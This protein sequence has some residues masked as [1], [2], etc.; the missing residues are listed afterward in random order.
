MS[1]WEG[2]S[3][4]TADELWRMLRLESLRIHPGGPLELTFVFR[5][6]VWPDAMFIVAVE[7]GVVRGLSLDD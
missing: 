4:R 3:P 7:G 6:E 2:P 5:D 1:G